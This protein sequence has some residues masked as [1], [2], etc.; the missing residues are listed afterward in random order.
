MT[1]PTIFVLVGMIGSGKSTYARR[2]AAEGA[3]VVCH[4]D[5]C[6]ML[7]AGCPVGPNSSGYE[8]EL[9]ACYR[10]MEEDL[11]RVA[12]KHGRD[13]VIDRTHLTRESR[14]RWTS[15]ARYPRFPSW[16]QPSVIAVVF[17]MEDPE[18]HALRR[19]TSDARGRTYDQWL[20]VARHHHDQAA[21]EPLSEAE[22]FDEIRNAPLGEDA[23]HA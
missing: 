23:N 4:D 19:F 17:P 3:L 22:D 21:R 1:M 9:R 10:E 15:F 5:L 11:A 2:R 12:I 20:Q 6:R 16:A 8:P 18:V 7:H 13:V 14:E